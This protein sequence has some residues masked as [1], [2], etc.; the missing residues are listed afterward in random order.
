MIAGVREA[1]PMVAEIHRKLELV[2]GRGGSPIEVKTLETHLNQTALA[3]LRIATLLIGACA[4]A[5]LALGIL[6]LFGALSDAARQRRRESAVRIAL[7]AQR[8]HM[9]AQVLKEG[10]RLALA[11]ATIGTVMSI[12]LTRWLARIAPGGDSPA[13][14][15]WLS[16]PAVLAVAVGLASVFPARGA[17]MAD[18]VTV[19]REDH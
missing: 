18:P 6:G 15:V 17:L 2:P 8:R 9:I 16:A 14:W 1:A 10:G 12:L 4:T 19:L 5:G 13:L 3:P 11:G 7:G